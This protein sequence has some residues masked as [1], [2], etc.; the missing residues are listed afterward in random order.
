M[1][2]ADGWTDQHCPVARAVD[3]IGDRWSLLIVRD[4]FDGARRFSEFQRSLG[5]AKNILADRLRTLVE[6][7]ILDARSN[8]QGTRQEYALTDRGRDLF[9]VIVSLRQWGESHTFTE[10]EQHSM[11]VDD[12]AGDAVPTLR[13]VNQQGVE[14]TSANTHVRK[15]GDG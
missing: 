1:P 9:L 12:T 14:L 13:L 4:A 8:E 3:L 15:V 11:L 2:K 6:L 10:H 7:G 5:I